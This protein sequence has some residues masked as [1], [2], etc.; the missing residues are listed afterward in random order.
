MQDPNVVR[1]GSVDYNN[2]VNE[3]DM[4]EERVVLP[5]EVQPIYL[6]TGKVPK[7]THTLSLSL[8]PLWYF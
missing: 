1:S 2:Y 6:V 3:T 8:L 7:H 4:S 5:K